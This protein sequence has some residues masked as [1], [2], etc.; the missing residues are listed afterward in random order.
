MYQGQICSNL[1]KKMNDRATTF[2]SSSTLCLSIIVIHKPQ[3]IILQ[4]IRLIF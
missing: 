2:I 3:H 1:E 4:N